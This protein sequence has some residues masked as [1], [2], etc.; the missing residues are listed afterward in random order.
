MP[1]TNAI[2][3]STITSF[4]WWQC[5]S[6][7]HESSWTWIFV[8][9]I[10]RSRAALT[11]AR[12]G[13]NTGTGAPAHTITRTGTRSAISASSSFT[14][15]AL[16]GPGSKSGSRCHEQTWTCR[17]APWIASAI[18][19]SALAPS[20]STCIELPSR[21]GTRGLR[22]QALGRGREGA[23]AGR[24]ASGGACGG[25]SSRARSRHRWRRRPDRE[26]S[27]DSPYPLACFAMASD[28]PTPQRLA[29]IR[30]QM[31][32]LSDYLDP[33]QMQERLE[34]LEA[35]MGAAGF[36]D[37]PDA[38]AKVGAEHT[39]TQRRLDGFTKL[40]ADAEDLESLAEMAEEDEEHRRRAR[41]GD[42]VRRDPSE[43]GRG[44]AAVHRRLRRRGRA[45]DRQRGRGRHR[46]PGLGR[47]GAAHGDALGRIA[48]LQDRAAGSERGRRGGHQVRHLP[49]E[50]R[51]RVRA[52][53]GREGRAPSG[54]AL[55]VR[56]REPAPDVLRGR[57]GRA[58]GRGGRRHRRSRT[59]TCRSTPTAPPAPAA[60]T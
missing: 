20:I 21:G 2:S 38:A 43:R 59:T 1:P 35:E 49:R 29:A 23:R 3:S 9:C 46:R 44:A 47:D 13:W 34:A 27:W 52:L 57:G 14:G 25:G 37:N 24:A 32:L 16:R 15:E 5:I 55:A 31:S 58:R 26:L 56:F 39:R 4:S 40:Q 10:I 30:E 7:V 8:P 60:S 54:A 41:R 17:F 45:G 22:P 33:A 6:R 28:Q 36:W 51:Q 42:R 50:R 18:R 53:L 11:V 12:R 19:G 48:R